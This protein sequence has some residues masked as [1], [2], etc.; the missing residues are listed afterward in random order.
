MMGPVYKRS[1][2]VLCCEKNC[3]AW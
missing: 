1:M 3:V 2:M